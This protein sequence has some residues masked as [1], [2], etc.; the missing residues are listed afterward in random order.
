M[1]G[2]QKIDCNC[3]DCAFMERDL[4]RF[5]QSLEQHHKW[6]MDYFN[7]IKA[8]LIKKAEEWVRRGFPDKASKLREEAGKMKFQFDKKEIAVHYGGCKKFFKPV[9]FIP[10]ICQLDTQDCFIHRKN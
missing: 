7:K 3:N 5:K 4:E 1:V 2:L 10:N 8:N 6:Q 9:S